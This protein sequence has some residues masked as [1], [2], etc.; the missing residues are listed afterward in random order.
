MDLH[1]RHAGPT[2]EERAAVDGLLGPPPSQWRGGERSSSDAHVA[3]GGREQRQQRH[4][5]L[6]ALQALQARV[7][8]ISETGLDYICTRLDVPPADAWGVATF[9]SLLSTTPRAPSLP[10]DPAPAASAP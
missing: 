2:D 6:P 1:V 3:L 10:A 4:L 8:W 9:Y 5:L 7:G